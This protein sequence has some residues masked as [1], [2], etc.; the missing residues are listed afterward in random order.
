MG[1]TKQTITG[2]SWQGILLGLTMVITTLKL[3]VLT[4][5]LDQHDFGIFSLVAIVLGLSE[6]VTQTG[7]NVTLVQSKQSIAYFLDTAWVIAIARGCIIAGIMIAMGLGMSIWYDE[8]SLF[9]WIS[10]AAAVPLIKGFI[11]PAIIS[12]YKELEFFKDALYRLSLV[13]VES[14]AIIVIALFTRSVSSFILGMITAA[15]FEVALSLFLFSLKPKF[16][17]L[18]SRAESIF[19]HAKGLSIAAS[20]AYLADTLDTFLVGKL[21]GVAQLGSYQNGYA[22]THKPTYGIAQA[23]SHS[24]FPIFSKFNHTPARLRRAY[25]R[26]TGVLILL[27]CIPAVPFIFFPDLLVSIVFGPQWM[28]VAPL[29]PWLVG[30][31]IVHAV[32]TVSYTVLITLEKYRLL[33]WHRASILLIFVPLVLFLAQQYGLVGAAAAVFLARVCTLPILAVGLWKVLR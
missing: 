16:I 25:F 32:F 18:R 28:E 7:I 30:A 20:L 5:L 11:N 33:N 17:F 14:V 23:L 2:F 26:S 8:P 1:Y 6:A 13:V 10:C 19:Y 24:T 22:L 27:L 31:G 21:L 4:R 15:L 12:Y 29:L 9:L 3:M